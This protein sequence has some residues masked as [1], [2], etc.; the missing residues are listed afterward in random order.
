MVSIT[1]MRRNARA[2]LEDL[3]RTKSPIAILQRS[4]PIAYIVD[5]ES[6]GAY[7]ELTGSPL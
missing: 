7:F 4:R 3:A 2:V 5:A 6:V 1:E